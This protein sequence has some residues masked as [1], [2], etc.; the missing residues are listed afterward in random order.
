MQ[1]LRRVRFFEVSQSK[2][3]RERER[4]SPQTFA[5]LML[6][7]GTDSLALVVL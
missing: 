1:Q 4:L 3:F 6:R 2:V 7:T 5:R